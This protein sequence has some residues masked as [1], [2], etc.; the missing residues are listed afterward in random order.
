MVA[1]TAE[2][3]QSLVSKYYRQDD[4]NCAT[5][6]LKVLAEKFNIPLQQQVIDAALAMHG[7]GKYGTQCGLVEGALMFMGIYGRVNHIP[8]QTIVDI[9]RE[10][11]G[12]F[13]IQFKSLQCRILRPQGFHPD[14]PPHLC[15]PL[16]YRTIQFSIDFIFIF[17]RPG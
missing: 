11:A 4:L 5:T 10:F 8:D 1:N 15:E 9:C 13:E 6:T 14:N 16:T 17:Y 2:W 12:K 3:I 7:A